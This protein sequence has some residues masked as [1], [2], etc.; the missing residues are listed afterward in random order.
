MSSSRAPA[1][2]GGAAVA[3]DSTAGY[4]LPSE[5]HGGLSTVFARHGPGRRADGIANQQ[6]QFLRNRKS[7]QCV[8]DTQST[9]SRAKGETAVSASEKKLRNASAGR[10]SD[11]KGA[12][13]RL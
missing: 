8:L 5:R 1:A 4:E 13:Q 6:L 11:G 9:S 12:W 2:L 7:G 10:G 3:Q